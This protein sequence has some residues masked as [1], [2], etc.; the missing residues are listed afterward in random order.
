MFN[1]RRT[2][3]TADPGFVFVIL[4]LDAHALGIAEGCAATA[5]CP[6]IR[7]HHCHTNSVR[8]ASSLRADMIFGK[9]R[10]QN[11]DRYLGY[12]RGCIFGRARTS[13]PPKYPPIF[14]SRRDMNPTCASDPDSMSHSFVW[15]PF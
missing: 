14:C 12:D 7:N 2:A 8:I 9:D 11:V 1:F 3:S 4:Q 15:R 6:R 10:T 13:G 5:S